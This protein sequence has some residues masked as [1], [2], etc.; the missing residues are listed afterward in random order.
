M[1]VSDFDFELPPE[2]IA[3]RPASPRD[4]ARMLEV[5]S[6]GLADL[7]M[8]DLPGRLR[9][10]DVL[11]INDTRVIPAQLHGSKGGARVGVTLHKREAADMWW[12][13]VKNVR[14]LKT[15]D[16]VEFGAGLAGE[17]LERG[18]EGAVLWRFS[19][20]GPLEAAMAA[21]GQMPLPPYIASKR[22]TDAQDAT[23]YQTLHATR[24]GAVA[25]PTAGLHFTPALWAAL[26]AAGVGRETVTLHVESRGHGGSQDAR[27]MGQHRCRHRRAAQCG[28]RRRRPG[29]RRGHHI[30]ATARI[31][32]GCAG[33]DPAFYR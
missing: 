30:A 33:P 20:N 32:C 23:D 9:A 8:R 26:A 5:S 27:R 6:Q 15:G 21:A 17:V 7:S 1:R 10:G 31:R 22:P 12:S 29:D 11:V 25:A 4:S 19:A 2:S 14:R 13:F 28:A 3:L 16:W 24:D 18:E